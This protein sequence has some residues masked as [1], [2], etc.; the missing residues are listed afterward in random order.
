MLPGTVKVQSKVVGTVPL[1]IVTVV[2]VTKVGGQV[3]W[4]GVSSCTIVRVVTAG[5]TVGLAWHG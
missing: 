1:G 5:C 4:V 3:V 2:L